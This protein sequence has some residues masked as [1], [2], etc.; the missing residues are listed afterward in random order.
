VPKV[1]IVDD[2]ASVRTGIAACLEGM[3]LTIGFAEDGAAALKLLKA[4]KFD[5]ALLDLQMPVLDGPTLVRL[6]RGT[7]INVEIVFVTAATSRAALADLFKLGVTDYIAKPFRREEVRDKVAK[8][9]ARRKKIESDAARS[10]TA[11]AARPARDVLVVAAGADLKNRLSTLLGP[12]VSVIAAEDGS[13]AVRH[14]RLFSFRLLLVDPAVPN[15]EWKALAPLAAAAILFTLGDDPALPADAVLPSPLAD[16]SPIAAALRADVDQVQSDDSII[17]VGLG[18][19]GVARGFK[20]AAD[21]L[22]EAIGRE[23]DAGARGV[24][25]DLT[26]LEVD[27]ERLVALVHQL[28][29]WTAEAGLRLVVLGSSAGRAVLAKDAAA[30]AVNFFED[31]ELAREALNYLDTE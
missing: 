6:L 30:P 27:T 14:A 28:L 10:M 19:G 1:L 25:V 9:L 20:R 8:A 11:L 7:T 31:V 29:D 22:S 4:E 26:A 17:H 23:A 21:L 5:V 15:L 24:V 3:N 12:S 16:P 18:G 2:M 13:A